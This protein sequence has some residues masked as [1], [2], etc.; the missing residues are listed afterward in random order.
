MMSDLEDIDDNILE[1][2]IPNDVP[3]SLEIH[4]GRCNEEVTVQRKKNLKKKPISR[5]KRERAS[6][7]ISSQGEEECEQR[8]MTMIER[9]KDKRPVEIFEMFFTDDLVITCT[10]KCILCN[11]K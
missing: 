4:G 8:R 7:N 5:W 3:G 6:F 10:A 1:D 2:T 11:S 9:V